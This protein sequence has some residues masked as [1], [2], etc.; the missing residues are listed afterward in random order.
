ME[1]TSSE[2]E[3]KKPRVE[4]ANAITTICVDQ[5]EK[6]AYSN[7]CFSTSPCLHAVLIQLKNSDEFV[8][9]QSVN[10]T[11][12]LRLIL[13]A[14]LKTRREHFNKYLKSDSYHNQ[15]LVYDHTHG[16]PIKIGSFIF[17][18][19][20]NFKPKAIK[21][22]NRKPKKPKM[23][24]QAKEAKAAG[25]TPMEFLASNGF[26]MS[27]KFTWTEAS[28]LIGSMYGYID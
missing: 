11:D 4:A 21:E 7:S 9:A 28:A 2:Q 1:S 20:E 24:E 8:R 26:H 12:V 19:P 18:Y 14:N 25:Y 3:T 10:G 15:K 16:T 6:L 13:A 5:I 17:T 23:S 27:G 22:D